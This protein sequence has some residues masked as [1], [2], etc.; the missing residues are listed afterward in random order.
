MSV[1]EGLAGVRVYENSLS[2]DPQIPKPWKGYAF[3]IRYQNQPLDIA[4]TQDKVTITNLGS[5][6]LSCDLAGANI[7]IEAGATHEAALK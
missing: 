6:P 5:A 1:V 4:I 2:I 7:T 3:Q